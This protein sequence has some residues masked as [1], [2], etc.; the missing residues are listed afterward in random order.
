MSQ[1]WWT[2][3]WLELQTQSGKKTTSHIPLL[4]KWWGELSGYLAALFSNPFIGCAVS[5]RLSYDRQACAYNDD[6]SKCNQTHVVSVIQDTEIFHV[7]TCPSHWAA[8]LVR[9]LQ[10][11]ASSEN[12]N[13][14]TGGFTVVE[15]HLQMFPHFLLTL[16]IPFWS[17]SK[18][19]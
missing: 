2:D 8:Q 17:V 4:T 13:I 16:R 7:Q 9:Q 18:F 10:T 12:C 15:A 6:N 3:G 1:G 14:L 5:Y 19:H 11:K